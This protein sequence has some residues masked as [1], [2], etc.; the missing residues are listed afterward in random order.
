MVVNVLF[1][2]ISSVLLIQLQSTDWAGAVIVAVASLVPLLAIIMLGE[3]L[4]KLI[5]G[6]A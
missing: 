4:P 5:A 6:R 3:V 1:F 2:V